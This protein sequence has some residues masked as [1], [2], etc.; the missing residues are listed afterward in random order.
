M[1]SYDPFFELIPDADWNACV[2]G[3]GNE[4]NY[5]SGYIEAAVQ[6]VSSVIDNELMDQRDTLVLPVLYNARHGIE[7]ALKCVARELKSVGMVSTDIQLTHDIK[8][9]WRSLVDLRVGDEALRDQIDGLMPFVWSLSM[10]DH[11]GQQL[12]YHE[13]REGI[14]SLGGVNVV[15]FR[16]L[17]F[18]LNRLKNVIDLILQRL[19]ELRR[20]CSGDFFTPK[21]SRRDLFEI[22]D[23]LPARSEWA[24]PEFGHKKD[25]IKKRYDLSSKEFECAL[26]LLQNNRETRTKLR[27]ENTLV[28]LTDELCGLLVTKHRE[29]IWADP[30]R[31]AAGIVFDEGWIRDALSRDD[32][33]Q[34]E[35]L[36][37][38]L[39]TLSTDEIADAVVIFNLGRDQELSEIYE[40]R[41]DAEIKKYGRMSNEKEAMIHVFNKLNFRK[42]FVRGLSILGLGELSH[43]LGFA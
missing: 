27:M 39:E 10:I 5:V 38:V 1:P 26:N 3:Q 13:T 42:E 30:A 25:Q 12:R 17:S 11:D 8:Q 29:S 4:E 9:L 35:A 21:L 19:W 41:L 7:L 23:T 16:L 6:L 37:F 2:G 34:R 14:A 15:N 18:S 32:S 22:A 24:T 36:S 43:E 40:Q 33:K 31:E 20:D 28:Y